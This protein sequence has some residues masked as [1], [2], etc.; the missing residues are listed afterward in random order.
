MVRVVHVVVLGHISTL[1]N[2]DIYMF[3]ILY[4]EKQFKF[5]ERDTEAAHNNRENDLRMAEEQE[6][7]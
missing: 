2:L 5:P 4:L 7:K 3:K 1:H 6:K